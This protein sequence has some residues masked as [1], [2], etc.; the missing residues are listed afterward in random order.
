MFWIKKEKENATVTDFYT[1]I[2]GDALKSIGEKVIYAYEWNEITPVRRDIVIVI[3]APNAIKAY[4]KGLK[5]I[6]WSQG[7]WPEESYMRH[8]SIIRLKA[9]GAIEK[10]ALKH[11]HFVFFVSESMKG[12]YEQKYHLD[13]TGKYYIMPC[14]NEVMHQDSF[15]TPK[16][17]SGN[18]FCYAGGTSVWQCF[19]QTIALYKKIEIHSKD[20]KLLL[21]VKEKEYA[22]K[23][24]SKY[25]IQNCEIDFVPVERLQERL[26]NVKFG[27][28][29]R[30]E[31]PVNYVATPTKALT[32]LANG[33]IP[34]YSS[35]LAGID[36]ILSRTDY[37]VRYEN[38]ENITDILSLMDGQIDK[39][40]IKS[41]YM[42]IYNDT[43]CR[44]EHIKRIA[45][46]FESR[47]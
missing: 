38:D 10:F 13:F 11:A 27:F 40:R 1:K 41:D 46:I 22:E 42:E 12:F 25:E 2:I 14:S 47:K 36:P 6:Y 18:V 43:Y 35:S 33:I 30:K 32:Y 28:V 34:I 45:K 31:D 37:K 21:L 24:V 39:Y 19:E 4:T 15:D 3:T 23:L 9:C 17:Y 20:A 44:D 26:R 8:K 29:I 7:V 16:K 5:Y